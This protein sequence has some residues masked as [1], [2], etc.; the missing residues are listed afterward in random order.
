MLPDLS[1][2]SGGVSRTATEVLLLN[3][4]L[5]SG[6]PPA[7]AAGSATGQSFT[8]ATDAGGA[9]NDPANWGSTIAPGSL[10][11][12][13]LDAPGGFFQVIRGS[14]DALAASEY[15]ADA[16]SGQFGF[17]TLTLHQNATAN[18]LVDVVAGSTVDAGSV[19]LY[20][21]TLEAVGAGASIAV[22]GTV[23][24]AYNQYFQS[25]LDV[26]DGASVQAGGLA[27]AMGSAGNY[28]SLYVAVDG[29]SRLE[30]GTAGAAAAGLLTVDAGASIAIAPGIDGILRIAAAVRND[31]V[32]GNAVNAS[33]TIYES[34]TIDGAVGGSGTL[35]VGSGA[36]D[37]TGAIAASQTIAFA[38]TGAL[39]LAQPTAA[40][41][42]GFAQG[43]YIELAGALTDASYAATGANTGVLTLAGAGGAATTLNLAGSYAGMSFVA[44]ES[45]S[46]GASGPQTFV[47]LAAPA[48][49]DTEFYTITGT[50][51]QQAT[52]DAASLD[53]FAAVV[54]ANT[55]AAA[56]GTATVVLSAPANG[57]LSNLAG[58]TFDGTTYT[59][60]G[61]TA[62]LQADLRGLVFTPTAQQ[63]APGGTET[64]GFTLTVA[65]AVPS[66][67]ATDATTSVV[68]TAADFDVPQ[69]DTIYQ[70]EL[71]R[72]PSAAELSAL[73]QDLSAGYSLPQLRD[74]IDMTQEGQNAL[75]LLYASVLGRLPSAGEMSLLTTDEQNG[76]SL[77]TLRAATAAGSE[78]QTEQMLVYADELGRFP[79]TA[80][81]AVTTQ[82][83]AGGLSLGGLEAMTAL[84]PEAQAALAQSYLTTLGRLPDA[85]EQATLTA[86]LGEGYTLAQ[87]RSITVGLPEAQTALTGLY[88]GVLARA[89]SAAELPVLTAELQDGSTLDEIRAGA[90]QGPEGQDDIAALVAN[91]LGTVP[92][93]AQIADATVQ[94]ASG[95]GQAAL[96]AELIGLASNPTISSDAA[97][98]LLT[99][100]SGVDLFAVGAGAADTIVGFDPAHDI[101]Q[102]SRVQVPDT[103]SFAADLSTA[104]GGTL[105]TLDA[106]HAVLIQGVAPA[107]IGAA[108]VRF[109]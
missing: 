98:S 85:G 39:Q 27:V 104:A 66:A 82:A 43:D 75:G 81:L 94:L 77:A 100:T 87:I 109:V 91:T 79:T 68:A 19:T 16:L 29:T 62:A 56:M 13:S 22:S 93:T 4:T 25:H 90:A 72:A 59:V 49:A 67:T 45:L 50:Q 83:L 61:S 44:F 92:T 95:I 48:A 8:W 37:V 34:T 38:G 74:A 64:T 73:D 89:P 80:E 53:P 65:D 5:Q 96:T 106:A 46:E 54:L 86:D 63:T 6:P 9:W 101:L 14:G 69:L 30:V 1:I 57:T 31:G 11:T 32:I 42:T 33:S 41:I 105:L 76:Y 17:G 20:S 7:P 52:T 15:A 88:Q 10:D 55:N 35:L 70:D 24:A 23:T 40:T 107:A 28:D 97:T 58:G 21:G 78:S 2:Y 47:S 18:G 102:V 26:L 71:G 60:T 99:G 108:N 84:L 103:A 3:G 51:S 36:L 12:V